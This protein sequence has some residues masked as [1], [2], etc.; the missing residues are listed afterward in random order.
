MLLCYV[1]INN[2][3]QYLRIITHY[4]Y[5]WM[6]TWPELVSRRS[7]HQHSWKFSV[8]VCRGTWINAGWQRLQRHVTA[9]HDPLASRSICCAQVASLHSLQNALRDLASVTIKLRFRLR[10]GFR[11]GLGLWL[12]LGQKFANCVW[13]I[14]KL[15]TCAAHFANCGDWQMH[16]LL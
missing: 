13:A 9:L 7:L 3:L 11:S 10:L 14:S 1:V 8:P 15:C 16:V 12:G 4:R 6:F 2:T 5:R